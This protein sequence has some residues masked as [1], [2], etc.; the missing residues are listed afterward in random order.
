MAICWE[1]R[2]KK[3]LTIYRRARLNAFMA[4]IVDPRQNNPK[5]FAQECINLCRELRQNWIF[6]PEKESVISNCEKSSQEI[7]DSTP[8]QLEAKWTVVSDKD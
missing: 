5:I 4:I 1:L 6:L 8:E 3:D 2:M 7:F